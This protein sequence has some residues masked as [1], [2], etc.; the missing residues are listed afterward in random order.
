[1]QERDEVIMA[2]KLDFDKEKNN[3][4]D[5]AIEE[6]MQADF[7][8][9]K[10]AE[11][12]KNEAF[13]RIREM[14]AASGH[15][16]NTENMVQRL[17]EKSTEKS[18]GSSGKKST[19]TAKSHKKFKTVYKTALGLTAAAAVFSTVCITNPAFAENIPL[20]G[21]VF[22]QLGNSMGFYGD[23]SKYAK[24][25][26]DSAEDAELADTDE[27]QEDGGNPQSAQ[28][29]DQYTT[30]NNNA[31]GT[32]EDNL[33]DDAEDA[34]DDVADGVGDAVDDIANGFDNYDDAHDY[35]LNRL[36]NDD[37]DG[38]YEVRNETKDEQEYRDGASGY[39]FEIYDTSD[40][41]G[42]KYG[43]FYVDKDTGKIYK[44]NTKTEKLEEYKK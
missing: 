38:K 28:A 34:V 22:K 43:D 16:E 15:T 33:V 23:Y 21:N 6:I 11:D 24:Q 17:Q 27:S 25:L 26:T 13:S 1:M 37:K 35:L 20:V 9:P 42:K 40:D 7:P 31:S 32:T 5:N 29:E 4:N 12:A 8:L 30:E 3:R 14:A 2:K 39:H 36:Q 10:Q 18:T 44:R 41:S 19:G